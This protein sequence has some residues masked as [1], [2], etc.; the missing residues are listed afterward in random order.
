[1]VSAST[2]E[3]F[4]FGCFYSYLLTMLDNNGNYTR[5]LSMYTWLVD[6]VVCVQVYLMCQEWPHPPLDEQKLLR[7]K[8]VG[9]SLGHSE[10]SYK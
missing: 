5:A 7:E 4:K 6:Q 1:M 8:R 9:Y 3:D 10:G 2:C